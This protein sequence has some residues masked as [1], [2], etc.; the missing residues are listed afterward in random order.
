[1]TD[2]YKKILLIQPPFSDYYQTNIRKYPLGLL[3]IASY[4]RNNIDKLLNG[5]QI[6]IYDSLKNNKRKTYQIP[7]ELK[8]T[9]D[10]FPD[11]DV[12]PFHLFTNYYY[13]G[14]SFDDIL[15][16]IKSYNPDIIGISSLFSAYNKEVFELAE[17]IKS[18]NN[19]IITVTGGGGV[20]SNVDLYIN[21]KNI[22][23]AIIGEG[24]IPFFELIFRLQQ[25]KQLK[26][27]KGLCY[28][29]KLNKE[30][31]KNERYNIEDINILPQIDYSFINKEN[32]YYGKDK[33]CFIQ[34]S[35]SCPCKCSYCSI[36]QVFGYKYKIK[37]INSVLKDIENGINAG[38][39]HFDF[40]DDNLI[41]NKKYAKELFNKIIEIFDVSKIS[42]SAMNGI[43]YDKL[44][45]EMIDLMKKCNFNSLN[46]AIVSNKETQ[47]N[48]N[49]YFDYESYENIVNYASNL[50]F[51]IVTYQIIGA[52]GQNIHS[53]F[54]TTK[55]ISKNKTLIGSSIF[56]IIENTPIYFEIETKS[57]LQPILSRS[58]AVFYENEDFKR[59][60]IITIFYLT[61]VLNFFK[62]YI[63]EENI[64]HSSI[65]VT[66]IFDYIILIKSNFE[67]DDLLF[68]NQ[69][70]KQLK[71][72]TEI[73][74]N[75]LLKPLGIFLIEQLLNNKTIYGYFKTNKKNHYKLEKLPYNHL[76]AY[77]FFNI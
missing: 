71:E 60:D 33:I 20:S 42:F 17:K 64:K 38:F 62:E 15:K 14:E 13:F 35:R 1:M 53:M 5:T 70:F 8:Y 18:Y 6:E 74:T 41:A 54:E 34:T 48:F 73:E 47:N 23:F 59:K 45:F 26:E 67:E 51:S 40:E 39:T 11:N 66:K 19:N 7:S 30:I 24:E 44:D 46:L 68:Y 4:L 76:L 22:D 12:S 31:V 69:L 3:Y 29:D 16:Y 32:Y 21:N 36:H 65:E 58:T 61:R 77:D 25:N 43:P 2:N 55:F 57:S 37:N 50:G 10:F 52:K 28:I 27:I 56:Y 75:L 63:I 49:R 9:K 72:N